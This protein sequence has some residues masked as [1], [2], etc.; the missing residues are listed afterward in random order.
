MCLFQ[1]K[2]TEELKAKGDKPSDVEDFIKFMNKHFEGKLSAVECDEV[3]LDTGNLI[4]M[5]YLITGPQSS[6]N[7]VLYIIGKEFLKN[8]HYKFQNVCLCYYY[9][10]HFQAIVHAMSSN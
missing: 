7:L 5:S 8:K 1:R 2:I 4:E 9:F 6:Q 3:E 10:N